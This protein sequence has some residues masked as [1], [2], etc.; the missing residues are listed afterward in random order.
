MGLV[1]LTSAELEGVLC[2]PEVSAGIDER[3]SLPTAC[4][5]G[6]VRLTSSSGMIGA[7]SRLGPDLSSVSV[8]LLEESPLRKGI[9]DDRFLCF[10]AFSADAMGGAVSFLLPITV[11]RRLFS[12]CFLGLSLFSELASVGCKRGREDYPPGTGAPWPAPVEKFDVC[13]EPSANGL[14]G[15]GIGGTKPPP[16]ELSLR[17]VFDAELRLLGRGVCRGPV[18]IRAAKVLISSAVSIFSK[19]LRQSS[20]GFRFCSILST[21]WVWNC[22]RTSLRWFT[23]TSSRDWSCSNM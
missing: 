22:V 2:C 17:M 21:S 12:P 15:G 10:F 5:G 14:G 13:R 7:K 18:A 9:K 11:P 23:L 20:A 19:A 1:P 16:A 3:L 8:W 4:I 6:T